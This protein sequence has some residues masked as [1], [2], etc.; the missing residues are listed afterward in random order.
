MPALRV[1]LKVD[2]E[3]ND[4]CVVQLKEKRNLS[5]VLEILL[6]LYHKDNNVTALVDAIQTGVSE[7]AVDSLSETLREMSNVLQMQSLLTEELAQEAEAGIAGMSSGFD[8]EPIDLFSEPE[9][10]PV[11][12]EAVNEQVSEL[13]AEVKDLKDMMFEVL[14]ALKAGATTAPVVAQPVATDAEETVTPARRFVPEP[15][16]VWAAP[17]QRTETAAP[18]VEKPVESVENSKFRGEIESA[19][20]LKSISSTPVE[21]VTYAEPEREASDEEARALA[22]LLGEF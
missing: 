11:A 18:Y 7:E 22:D 2:E 3:L 6:D 5:T 1:V 16:P 10:A 4:N 13:A 12:P 20:V 15:E 8:D 14:Q 19:P 17:V 21:S 9:P